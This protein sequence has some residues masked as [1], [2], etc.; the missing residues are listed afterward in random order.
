M[1]SIPPF[2]VQPSFFQNLIGSLDALGII[3]IRFHNLAQPLHHIFVL[4][5]QLGL[6]YRL[7]RFALRQFHFLEFAVDGVAHD[8]RGQDTEQHERDSGRN[9]QVALFHGRRHSVLVLAVGIGESVFRQ[10][11]VRFEGYSFGST[12][13]S[14]A[15]SGPPTAAAAGAH[16]P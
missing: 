14:A 3:K 10:G 9:H 5:L 15:R 16:V 11:G 12:T 4:F 13:C 8:P 6:T 7:T 2:P 1:P